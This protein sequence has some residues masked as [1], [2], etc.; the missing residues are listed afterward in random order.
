[1][2]VP[3]VAK[4][5]KAVVGSRNMFRLIFLV[6]PVASEIGAV[7]TVEQIN[8]FPET[9]HNSNFFMWLGRDSD[10]ITEPVD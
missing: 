7:C 10:I 2:C 8:V 1:M 5:R 3:G 9:E 4:D 6:L